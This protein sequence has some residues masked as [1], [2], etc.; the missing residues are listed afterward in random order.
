M[1]DSDH[2]PTALD[3]DGSNVAGPLMPSVM[4]GTRNGV[5]TGRY[6]GS[7]TAVSDGSSSGAISNN[8]LTSNANTSYNPF[9]L[10]N[11]E[12]EFD[13][14]PT[15][16]WM[17]LGTSNWNDATSRPDS[18]QSV[19]PVSTPTPRPPSAPVYSPA[20]PPMQSP[21][22][23]QPSPSAPNPPTP[24]NNPFGNSFPFSPLP[25]SGFPVDEPL[26][27]SKENVMEEASA[28]ADSGRLRNL[29][30]KPPA[31]STDSSNDEVRNKHRI[32]KDLLNQEDDEDKRIENRA[33]PRGLVGGR[34]N[35]VPGQSSGSGSSA[36]QTT[37]SGSSDQPKHANNMLL[38]VINIYLQ[39]APE[40]KSAFYVGYSHF[41][42]Y[43]R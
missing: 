28:M 5:P 1:L 40:L 14:L 29:L 15:S 11:N 25:E 24:A 19:T 16:T 22:A 39:T 23:A 36:G 32:L 31:S 26:K 4:N 41:A 38:R 34:S 27:D 33:S 21:F 9:V 42:P 12:L 35:N 6:S 3:L 17:E 8:T 7:T 43:S 13:F 10:P 30:T 2:E 20:P 37:A 18:C